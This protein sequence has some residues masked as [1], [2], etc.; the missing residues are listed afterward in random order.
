M[1]FIVLLLTS[2]AYAH[3]GEDHGAPAP[4]AVSVSASTVNVAAASESFEAVLRI[5]RGA[6]KASV[7]VTLLLSDYATSAPVIGATTSLVLSGPAAVQVDLHGGTDAGAYTASATFPEHGAYSGAL[8]VTTSAISDLLAVPSL[9]IDLLPGVAPVPPDP[10]ALVRVGWTVALVGGAILLGVGVGVLWGR[11][12][13]A[14]SL[15]CVLAISWGGSR[16]WAHGGVDDEGPRSAATT[17]SSGGAIALPMESAF[18]VGLRTT[19]VE[20]GAFQDHVEALGR[21]ISRPGDSATLRAPVSGVVVAAAAGFPEPGRLVHS[22]DVLAIVQETPG[23]AD[24][25]AVAQE[26]SDAL[27][28]VAEATRALALAERDDAN[29][30]SLGASLSERERLDRHASVDVARESLA[31][32]QSAAAFVASGLMV[33]I[34]APLTGRLGPSTVRP[35]DQVSAGDALFRVIDPTGLWM[36][37]RLPE[38]LAVGLASGVVAD[39]VSAADPGHPLQAVVLDAGQEADP[40]TGT[41]IVTLAVEDRDSGLRPGM[42]A[43]AWIGRGVVRDAVVVPDAAVVDSNGATLAFVKTGPESFEL[44]EIK[45]GGRAGE[46]W[47][48]LAGLR[49]GERVVTDGTY[50]L[51]SL[52]G[53]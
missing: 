2:Y 11:R 32:A 53:R 3:G 30:A 49:P 20:H 31:Q 14:A 37:A 29:V 26:R 9:D 42:G 50:T 27:T 43:S 35:G 6:A 28:R 8:T 33:T 40:A 12:R 1:T 13:G 34:R 10:W 25:A 21:F 17:S 24:R 18:L 44:R 15:A 45:L 4:A 22:G 19:R 5:G 46:R 41:V 16:V 36:E 7:P 23:G 51:R 52:A 38:R 39:V 47:E 48:V